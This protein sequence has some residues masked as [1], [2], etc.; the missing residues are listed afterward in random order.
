MTDEIGQV[1]AAWQ[2]AGGVNELRRPATD[3]ELASAEVELGRP[4]PAT[5]QRLYE[6]SDGLSVAYGSLNVYPLLTGEITLVR[7]SDQLR[8]WNWPIP[9]D[10]L[11]F[12]DN[13]GDELFGIWYPSDASPAGPTPVVMIGEVFQGPNM[14]LV[15][16]DL[17]PFLKAWSAY[18]L[19][20]ESPETLDALGVPAELQPSNQQLDLD[21]YI[22]WADPNLP[23]KH[24][25]P[26][27]RGLDEDTIRALVAQIP[28]V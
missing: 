5:L 22:A 11:M 4:L 23:D 26:Y 8:S 15:G 19:G 27:T 14:A 7:A 16:T 2:T 13:G 21:A 9:Q 6:F 12:G 24:P 18:Y 25:D 1:V 20:S 3:A 28:Y 17:A 10:V